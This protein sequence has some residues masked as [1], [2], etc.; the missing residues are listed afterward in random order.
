MRWTYQYLK[1]GVISFS[2]F[3]FVWMNIWHRAQWRNF[4]CGFL[5][6]FF[7]LRSSC[8]P[9][10]HTHTHT[11]RETLSRISLMYAMW[12][13]QVALCTL[14]LLSLSSG[15]ESKARSCSEVRQA[16]NAKG[17]S[18]VNAPHQE[19]SGRTISAFGPFS[20]RV[21]AP[22]PPFQIKQFDHD[23]THTHRT[24]TMWSS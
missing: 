4:P 21:N 11:R 16:Y 9:P 6:L 20:P 22:F 12:R 14:S 17:F 3:G 23:H 7:F 24:W 19:I 2:F 5:F 1:W 15:G 10:Q 18:L 8:F 13:L